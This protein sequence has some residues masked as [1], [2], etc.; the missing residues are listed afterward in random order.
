MVTANSCI[1]LQAS[2]RAYSAQVGRASE[3]TPEIKRTI[4]ASK[5]TW[6]ICIMQSRRTTTDPR[7][8]SNVFGRKARAT[9]NEKNGPE[10]KKKHRKWETRAEKNGHKNNKHHWKQKPK[11]L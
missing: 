3:K 1:M 5:A 8:R 2:R 4:D 11:K 9:N 10:I 7:D 6:A